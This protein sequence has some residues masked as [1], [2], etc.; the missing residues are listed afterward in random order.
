MTKASEPCLDNAFCVD[1][2][3]W[4]HICGIS[5]PYDDPASWA[6][7]E[8]LVER[9]TRGLMRILE[10]TATRATFLTVGWIAERYPDLIRDL[11]AAGHEIGCHGYHHRLVF[12]QTEAEFEDDLGRALEALRRISGQPVSVYRAPGFSMVRECL[13]AYPILA[14][15]GIAVDVSPVPARRDHGG[16]PEFPRDPFRLRTGEGEMGVFPVTVMRLL[17][18][19]TPFSGGGYLRLLP[20]RLIES[21]FRQNLSQGRPCMLYI[22]P[23]EIDPSQ[24][25]LELPPLKSFKYYV[26]L[27]STEAKLQR[28][29]R[30]FRFGTV[31]QV[32][33]GRAGL[34]GYAYSQGRIIRDSG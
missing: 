29:T 9:N 26:G 4:F 31:S 16:I 34:A 5:T 28:L 17:G 30:S 12:E 2:E 22:H 3:E 13:W 20:A 19:V 21:G 8:P 6:G 10:E 18:R 24:P 23:R 32:M 15:H 27:R 33:T 25:R 7:A 14:R 11:A 1:L